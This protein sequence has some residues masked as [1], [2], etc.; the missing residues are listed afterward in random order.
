MVVPGSCGRFRAGHW[1]I[2]TNVTSLRVD[3]DDLILSHGTLFLGVSWFAT[4]EHQVPLL[5]GVAQLN[6]I[7]LLGVRLVETGDVFGHP[8]GLRRYP[9]WLHGD[10]ARASCR[11]KVHVWRS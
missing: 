11:A 4:L 2:N 3:F 7:I 10:K 1:R 9:L 8:S 5:F 6:G